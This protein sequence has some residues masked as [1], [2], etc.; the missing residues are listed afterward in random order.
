MDPDE[1]SCICRFVFFLFFFFFFDA[2]V[3]AF[4]DKVHCL[5][6]VHAL[7][8]HYSCIVHGTYIHFIQ[9]KKLKMGPTALL[10]RL[11]IILIQCFQFSTK[12]TVSKWTLRL[13]IFLIVQLIMY[14]FMI[15]MCL[16]LNLFMRM[17]ELQARIILWWRLK[18]DSFNL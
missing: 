7:F 8:I 11:K 1:F 18:Y 2:H 14:N 15:K 9:K 16:F 13:L 5:Y 17:Y 10:T 12:W 3:S 6:T 4:R